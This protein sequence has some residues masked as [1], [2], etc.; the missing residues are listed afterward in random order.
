MTRLGVLTGRTWRGSRSPSCSASLASPVPGTT[1]SPGGWTTVQLIR[2]GSKNS[3][4]RK[5]PLP[6]ISWIQPR[7]KRASSPWP[8]TSGPGASDSL[9]GPHRHREDQ[10][11]GLSEVD[12]KPLPGIVC[13]TSQC[14]RFKLPITASSL[15]SIRRRAAASSG[16]TGFSTPQA[17]RWR[18]RGN[19]DLC[20]FGLAG[21]FGVGSNVKL[22]GVD[23]V[24][25]LPP[26]LT[27]R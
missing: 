16:V 19:R 14:R 4:V 10:M 9:P 5:R 23:S 12:A 22:R 15:R 20:P 18:D 17:A 2:T 3:R 11:G 6:R 8:T 7:S 25:C 1:G 13:S 24:D 26:L 27:R 21:S